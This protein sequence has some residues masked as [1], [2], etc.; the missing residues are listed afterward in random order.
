M[1][2]S[3]FQL[4]TVS[5]PLPI[6]LLKQ[7]NIL[8]VV[9]SDSPSAIERL[10]FQTPTLSKPRWQNIL[11]S[12]YRWLTSIVVNL[13]FQDSLIPIHIYGSNC[14]TTEPVDFNSIWTGVGRGTCLQGAHLVFS[15]QKPPHA[16]R[17]P[18]RWRLLFEWQSRQRGDAICKL[19]HRKQDRHASEYLIHN[20][21]FFSVYVLCDIKTILK[22]I[23]YNEFNFLYFIYSYWSMGT[24]TFQVEQV[25]GIFWTA[26]R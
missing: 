1:L 19:R 6:S 24:S 21:Q 8:T 4:L 11:T 23:W 2:F 15:V 9:L 14:K 26:N 10:V 17:G 20:Q 25:F 16:P 7:L 12:T 3:T 18:N 22:I 13:Y 5:L